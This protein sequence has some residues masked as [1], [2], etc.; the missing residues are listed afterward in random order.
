[1]N[2]EIVT[3]IWI[4]R[5]LYIAVLLILVG[6]I[7]DFLTCEHKSSRKFCDETRL[8]TLFVN[9]GVAGCL[10]SLGIIAILVAL[11]MIIIGQSLF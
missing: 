6:K 7:G 8:N 1:M 5:T 11:V 10:I 9:I 4:F 2:E 3:N